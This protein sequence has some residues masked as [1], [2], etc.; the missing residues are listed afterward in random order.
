MLGNGEPATGGLAREPIA[1]HVRICTL[2]IAVSGFSAS[3]P[4]QLLTVRIP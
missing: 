2:A 1:C 3:P 4:V